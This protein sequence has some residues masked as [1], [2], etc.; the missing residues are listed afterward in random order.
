MKRSRAEEEALKALYPQPDDR[1]RE[2][3]QN[4]E[5]ALR[6]KLDWIQAWWEEEARL[7]ADYDG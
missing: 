2:L 3:Y 6:E 4:E 1:R 5:P 7:R